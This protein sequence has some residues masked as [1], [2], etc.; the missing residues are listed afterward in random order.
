MDYNV[1]KK[2][3]NF[4]DFSKEE[5]K[6]E[7]TKV[8]RS[9]TKN[10]NDTQKFPNNSKYKFN[11]VTRKM[12][13]MSLDM[14]D[15]SIEAIEEL[16]ENVKYSYWEL[17]SKIDK[18]INSNIQEIPY[19]GK[20]IDTNSIKAEIIQLIREL[21][22]EYKIDESKKFKNG[23]KVE[24]S[25][26]FNDEWSDYDGMSAKELINELISSPCDTNSIKVKIISDNLE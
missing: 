4:K 5:E 24:L 3:V 19:E 22:P 17:E 16:D 6:E 21:C 11:K 20:E 25:I 9:F 23:R 18:I 13:D 7:L 1:N 2:I 12:D 26:K 14:V 15:D 8:K 10:S